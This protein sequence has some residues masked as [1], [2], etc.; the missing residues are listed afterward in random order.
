VF[1]ASCG[2]IRQ[3]KKMHKPDGE[4]HENG[5]DNSHKD[6]VIVDFDSMP[7]YPKVILTSGEGWYPEIPKPKNLK[8]ITIQ[9]TK[10][11]NK[12]RDMSE[13][14]VVYKIPE[15]M[16]IFST[17]KVLLRIAKTKA[18]ISIYDSL[19]GVVRTSEIPVTQ[20]MEVRL[21]DPQ[22]SFEILPDNN[23]VQMIEN[24]DTYTEW[25]WNV[26]PI[27]VGNSNL[28][29]VISIIRDGNKKDIVYEDS[30]MVEKDIP[31]QIQSFWDKY[32][33]WC[34]GTLILPFFIFLY[35]KREKK[36]N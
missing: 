27:K 13:G 9:N 15:T 20:T 31:V 10:V 6:S 32:W 30:V 24:G 19:D 29:I 33:Q 18:V 28:K 23:G 25:S 7:N 16:K 1:I 35:K 11:I 17:Y 2:L 5:N 12:S 14:R 22:K 3:S 34:I 21:T 26:K 8:V 4:G 36:I